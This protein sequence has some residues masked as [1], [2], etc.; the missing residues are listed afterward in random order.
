[1]VLL[2]SVPNKSKS[3][4]TS[5][6]VVKFDE[7]G[8]AEHD[9]TPEALSSCRNLGWYVD[10][11]VSK[12]DLLRRLHSQYAHDSDN[13]KKLEAQITELEA[14]I[15]ADT[16]K[17]K[18]LSTE[19]KTVTTDPDDVMKRLEAEGQAGGAREAAAT[20]NVAGVKQPPQPSTKSNK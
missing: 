14:E 11:A 6:G 19:S 5:F 16:V 1:M 12:D 18:K 3:V 20:V 10:S 9:V 17:V 4:K 15:T 7:K 2:Q 13:L 8:F